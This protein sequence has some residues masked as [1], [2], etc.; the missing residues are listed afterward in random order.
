MKGKVS[1]VTGGSGGIGFA[2]AEAL[3]EMGGDIALQVRPLSRPGSLRR[4][5]D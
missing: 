3:A 5:V 2:A 4:L 1:I